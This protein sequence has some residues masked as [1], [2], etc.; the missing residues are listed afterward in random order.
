M[1]LAANNC[2]RL[3]KEWMLNS[4]MGGFRKLV[5]GGHEQDPMSPAGVRGWCRPALP[6]KEHV[7][8]RAMASLQLERLGNEACSLALTLALC[9]QLLF[10]RTNSS[11]GHGHFC[12]QAFGRAKFCGLGY[13]QLA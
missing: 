7:A 9:I 6:L 1:Q 10:R 4:V 3:R 11:L 13:V 12:C 5:E 2:T 8:T